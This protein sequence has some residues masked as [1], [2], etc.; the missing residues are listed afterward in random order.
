M[1]RHDTLG[2]VDKPQTCPGCNTCKG[3]LKCVDCSSVVLRCAECTVA[4]HECLM[5]H[6]LEVRATL[7]E[8]SS[9]GPMLI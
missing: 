5:L 7:P 4:S 8:Y 2:D 9:Y 1:L 3:V 6:R